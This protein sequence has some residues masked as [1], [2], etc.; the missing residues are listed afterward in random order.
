[1]KLASDLL[2]H[3]PDVALALHRVFVGCYY[4]DILWPWGKESFGECM[5]FLL[6]GVHCGFLAI[7]GVP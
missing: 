6:V 3:Y 1:M 5:A 4:H 7:S 2:C